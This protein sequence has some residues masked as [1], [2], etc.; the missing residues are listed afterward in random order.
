LY[1]TVRE[2]SKQPS[3]Y[4]SVFDSESTRKNLGRR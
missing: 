2:D 4:C 1:I 3:D